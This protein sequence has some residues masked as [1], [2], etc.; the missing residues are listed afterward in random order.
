MKICANCKKV[1]PAATT[2]TAL[3]ATPRARKG[4]YVFEHILVM[5]Q[6]MGRF[7]IEG[8]N[9]HHKNGVRDDNRIENLELWIRPQPSGVRA[10]DAVE[11][12]QK[13]LATYDSV[14]KKL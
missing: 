5:E 1:A 14:L 2:M 7:L 8:E 3:K 6:Y 9:V 12:A 4:G 10:K 13:I 11:W